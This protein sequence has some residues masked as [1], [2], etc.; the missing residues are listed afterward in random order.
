MSHHGYDLWRMLVDEV[1]GSLTYAPE[2]GCAMGGILKVTFCGQS[3]PYL[4]GAFFFVVILDDAEDKFIL[5]FACAGGW[6][7]GNE[8]R[9][10]IV[11]SIVVAKLDCN[12]PLRSV[13]Q[14]IKV[15]GF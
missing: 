3:I 5:S 6:R 7:K 13:G 14:V 2:A 15:N 10:G 8:Q 11:C 12:H 9:I 1:P 4:V